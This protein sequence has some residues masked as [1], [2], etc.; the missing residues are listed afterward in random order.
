M[1]KLLILNN[2]IF[3]SSFYLIAINSYN[4]LRFMIALEFNFLTIIGSFGTLGV[5][6]GLETGVVL[7][8]FCLGIAACEAVVGFYIALLIYIRRFSV[9][10]QINNQLKG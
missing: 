10:F 2:W 6:V 8:I 9:D 3:F 5:F 4:F 7:G 1:I